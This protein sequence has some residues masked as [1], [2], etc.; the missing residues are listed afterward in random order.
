M[1]RTWAAITSASNWVQID[2]GTD[3]H[4]HLILPAE[5]FCVAIPRQMVAHGHAG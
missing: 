1:N 3:D 2:L 5:R 4:D